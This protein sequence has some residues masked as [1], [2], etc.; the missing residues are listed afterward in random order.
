MSN[1]KAIR[2]AVS[3]ALQTIPDLEE[4]IFTNRPT[5]MWSDECPVIFIYSGEEPVVLADV[6]VQRYRRDYNLKIQIRVKAN[7]AIDDALDE[8]ANQVEDVMKLDATFGDVAL[9]SDLQYTSEP[10]LSG[11]GQANFASIV[12]EYKFSYLK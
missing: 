8:I 12:L 6:T 11:D 9:N 2:D 4:K 5:S 1:R 7:D 3:E 10:E